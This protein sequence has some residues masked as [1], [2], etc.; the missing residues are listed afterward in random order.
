MDS[1]RITLLLPVNLLFADVSVVFVVGRFLRLVVDK[2]SQRIIYEDMPFVEALVNLCNAI[3]I[4]REHSDLD[5]EE[6]LYNLLV[7]LY[8]SPESLIAWTDPSLKQ[9]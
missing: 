6:E 8:R 3:Y 5:M 1:V 2:I 4:A 9:D 7:R